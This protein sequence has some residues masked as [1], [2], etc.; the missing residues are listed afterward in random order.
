M[1]L[2][3]RLTPPSPVDVVPVDRVAEVIE[4]AD[5]EISELEQR[6]ADL[7]ARAERAEVDAKTSGMDPEASTWGILRLQ[8]F[9]DLLREE[10]TRDAAATVDIAKHRAR[11]RLE[12]ARGGGQATAVGLSLP[13]MDRPWPETNGFASAPLTAVPVA[14]PPEPRPTP[15]PVPVSVVSEP[16]GSN[17]SSAIAFAPSSAQPSATN[18]AASKSPTLLA[19]VVADQTMAAPLAPQPQYAEPP[20]GPAAR[21]AEFWAT[22]TTAVAVAVPEAPVAAPPSVAP[23]PAPVPQPTTQQR[24]LL[25]RI[26][27]S[28]IFEVLAVLAIL[29]FILLRLS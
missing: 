5:R 11:L 16:E 7:R 14:V 21:E 8:R 13:V 27:L 6:A 25:R 24:G 10:T 19:P 20:T 4:S 23:Q 15:E 3:P 29:V 17:G 26:P 9:L 2:T 1:T 22:P 28:A 18:G 12:D